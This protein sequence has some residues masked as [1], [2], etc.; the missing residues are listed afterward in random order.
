M[1]DNDDTGINKI[2]TNTGET[3]SFNSI[4]VSTTH[5]ILLLN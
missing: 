1:L 5:D 2:R 3:V 4:I